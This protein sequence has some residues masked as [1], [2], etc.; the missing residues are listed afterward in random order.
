MITD[1]Q[2]FEKLK[3]EID[4]VYWT[5]KMTITESKIQEGW[6]ENQILEMHGLDLDKI[7]EL[8]EKR[9]EIGQQKII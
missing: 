9:N 2:K 3:P 5:D 7:E 4:K 8:K 6:L 1:I